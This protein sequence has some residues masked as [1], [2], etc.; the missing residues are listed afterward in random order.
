MVERLDVVSTFSNFGNRKR[1]F[2][3]TFLAAKV[4]NTYISCKFVK[5]SDDAMRVLLSWIINKFFSY[6][7]IPNFR[8]E[9][10]N[11][12]SFRHRLHYVLRALKTSRSTSRR[13]TYI[14]Q[15]RMT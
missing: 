1:Y 11:L 8:T 9:F 12:E 6:K 15:T 4:I 13:Q 7:L 14:F 10:Y 3:H 2:I 5:N